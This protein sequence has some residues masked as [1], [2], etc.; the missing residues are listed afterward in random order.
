MGTI[1]ARQLT[2]Q[3]L[4]LT[5]PCAKHANAVDPRMMSNTPA[6]VDNAGIPMLLLLIMA[7]LDAEL[8]VLMS[9]QAIQTTLMV[10]KCAGNRMLEEG[11]RV[12]ALVKPLHNRTD[13]VYGNH[14][15]N[16][17]EMTNDWLDHPRQ[18]KMGD[19]SPTQNLWIYQQTT[20]LTTKS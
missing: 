1:P 6:F 4:P 15:S 12:Y 18:T 8:D 13:H 7:V 3:P 9:I 11:Q 2:H 19:N 14:H 20:T 16:I 5:N 10:H 17:N